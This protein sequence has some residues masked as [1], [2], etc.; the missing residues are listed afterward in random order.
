MHATK[1][2][3]KPCRAA[4]CNARKKLL[5]SIKV[6]SSMRRPRDRC[7]GKTRDFSGRSHLRLSTT[8][9]L[10][11]NSAE[12]C[13]ETASLLATRAS[14]WLGFAPGPRHPDSDLPP[15]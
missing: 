9:V 15:L 4:N 3:I 6:S 8:I 12:K 14:P 1:N 7:Q 13:Y 5:L 11:L 2:C 10:F